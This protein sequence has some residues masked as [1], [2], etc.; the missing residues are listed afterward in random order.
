[1]KRMK[2][3]KKST[4]VVTIPEVLTNLSGAQNVRGALELAAR[5]IFKDWAHPG[6]VEKIQVTKPREKN[7]EQNE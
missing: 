1:M 4:Y 3:M 6:L 7:G 5:I 2:K